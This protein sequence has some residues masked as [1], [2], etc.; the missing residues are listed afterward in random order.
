MNIF[1]M[2][3]HSQRVEK[4]YFVRKPGGLLQSRVGHNL[5]GM[6]FSSKKAADYLL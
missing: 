1:F 3:F 2:I 5:V 6:V 4:I